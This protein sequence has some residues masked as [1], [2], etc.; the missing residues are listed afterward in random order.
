M[1]NSNH[2]Y[3]DFYPPLRGQGIGDRRPS[4]VVQAL[5]WAL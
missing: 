3:K 4:G 2:Y 1:Q 5:S